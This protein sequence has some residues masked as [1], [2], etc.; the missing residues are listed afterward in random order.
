MLGL[1]AQQ[2]AILDLNRLLGID[3]MHI[4]SSKLSLK[5][6]DKEYV[7]DIDRGYSCF[8]PFETT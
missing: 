2:N 3:M 4:I 7:E 5:L 1:P 6:E 8:L